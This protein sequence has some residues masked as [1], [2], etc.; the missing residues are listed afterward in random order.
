[1]V[2]LGAVALLCATPAAAVAQDAADVDR[3]PGIEEVIEEIIATGSR[4]RRRDFSAPSPIAT[5]DR[6]LLDFTGQGTLETALNQMPQVT[7]DFDRTANNPG[8]GTARINLRGLGA[9]RTLV[10]LNGRRLAPSG[11]GSA[12]DVNTLPQALIERVEVITGGASTVYGSD[13]V[14]GVVNFITRNDFDGLT[15]DVSA[16][17]T[18]QGDSNTY[19]VS[20]AY[21]HDFASGRGNVAVFGGYYDREATYADARELTSVPWF[22]TWEGELVVGG[23]FRVADGI[24][25]FPRVDWGNGPIQTIFDADGN[26]RA[27][28]PDND[29]YNWAPWNFLQVPLERYNAGLLLNY[30]L[31]S[32]AEL[33][34]EAT[35]TSSQVR[36]VLAPIP[37]FGWFEF[38]TDNPVMTPATQQ[39]FADYGIPMGDDRVLANVSRRFEEL[40]P[41]ILERNSDYTRLVAGVKGDFLSDWEFDAWLTYAKS[42]ESLFQL[43]AASRARFQQGLL[44]DPVTGQCFDPSNGC[45]PINMF[46]AGNISAEAIEFLRLPRLEN[47]T[48]RDQVLASAFV[49]GELFDTRAGGVET[50]FGVEWRRDDGNFSAD[51]YL[52]SGDAL[53]YVGNAPVLGEETVYEVYT[54]LLLPLADGAALAEYLA[55]EVGG[56]YSSYDNAGNVETYKVGFEWLP[57]YSLRVRGM[58]QRSV[59]APNLEEAFREESVSEG[60]FAQEPTDDPCSASSDPV[61]AGNVDKC[62]ATGLP[63]E[64][65]GV[66]EAFQFP[67]LFYWGGNRDLE[68]ETADTLTLGIVIAPERLAGLQLAVDYFDLQLEGGIGDLAAASACFDSANTGNLFCDRLKRDPVTFNVNEVRENFINRGLLL[69]RGIDTQLNFSTDLPDALAIGNAGADVAIDITWTH[70]RELSSRPTV[71]SAEL[72][73]AGFYGWPCSSENEGMTFPADRVTT[74]LSYVSGALSAHLSWRWIAK[75]DN[76]APKQSGDWGFPDPDLAVPYVEA[77]NYF[78]LGFAWEFNEHLVAR[79]TI[80]NLTD[81]E[82]PMMADAVWDKNTDTRMYDIF[83]RSYTLSFSLEY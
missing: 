17:A 2:I 79:L 34:V 24:V 69:T 78:D 23:S 52:F 29:A 13:A 65:I 36:S 54:E 82:A 8:D 67:A 37:A 70:L 5:I 1:L 15:L 83:G 63:P 64:Q 40:G 39:F 7:P 31:G 48:A 16:Y 50:A 76:A 66:Y 4:L 57:V 71:F 28:D 77:K 25:A 68:P 19:D 41:R 21:G 10:V 53:G 60:S 49:R 43:N 20:A 6:E 35:Y 59:R 46:G 22:D 38:N 58:F 74:N 45:V 72:D 9:G 3:E 44:V 73:C 30:D 75:T 81:T 26:P 11:I 32:R 14:T 56:R 80:A 61:A 51:D 27:Y 18:E 47:V 42:D 62:I 55:L 12:V 33:Y